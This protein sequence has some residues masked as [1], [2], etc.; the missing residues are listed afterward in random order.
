MLIRILSTVLILF[1]LYM[2][3]KQGWAMLYGKPQM[4]EMFG[5][6][7][8]GKTGTAVLGVF[9]ILGA[10]LVLFPKTFLWGN[11]ITAAGILFIIALHLK[12]QDLK[13]VA[14]ELPF[15]LLSWLIIY[16]QHPLTR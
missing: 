11:F 14:I 16:L 10:V 7:N 1:A 4:L 2:G 5:K 9:T 8:I 15:F 3:I 12:D 6:W 13:G